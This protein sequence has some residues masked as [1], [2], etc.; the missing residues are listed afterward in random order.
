M[1]GNLGSFVL[2]FLINGIIIGSV[3]A[4]ISLGFNVIYKTTGII[5]FAQGEFVM[6]GG[7][8]A[9]VAWGT[10]QWPLWLAMLVGVAAA[11]LVGLLLDVLAIR[12]VRKAS[13][14]THII[15]T[16]GASIVIRALVSLKIT[17]P[18]SLNAVVEGSTKLG[19]TTVTF[20]DLVSI[21]V[22]A[23]CMLLT[24][25]FFRMT[26]TG[27]A[28]RACADNPE[29]ARLSG[30]KIGRMSSA[31]FALSA[32]LAGVAG[33]LITPTTSMDFSRGTM[34]GLKGFAAA[35][36]GG[37]GNPVGGVIGGILFGVLE[38]F[39]SWRWSE[40]KDALALGIVVIILL[41]RPRGLLSK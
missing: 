40:Y 11:G 34:L 36:L 9:G 10:L 16:I 5:N 30:V 17:D 21:A 3:Y 19:G 41:V 12:P 35:I 28:M 32:L 7:V 38:V 27:R 18:Q 24:S 26:T 29:G 25:A 22:A 1:A 2:L 37:L 13:A 14:V 23:A 6:I 20:N 15:I 39:T 33:I 4:L 8:A 31:A